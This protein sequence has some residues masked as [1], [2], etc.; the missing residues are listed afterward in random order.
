VKTTGELS[1]LQLDKLYELYELKGDKM[2]IAIHE[3]MDEFT[4]HEIQLA[5]G[6]CIY[7]F[8]DGYADQF[9]GPKG[10]K[11]MYKNFKQ[12]LIDNSQLSMQEQKEILEKQ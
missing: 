4:N 5:Q 11:F 1:T 2:P 7:L 8:T 12:L 9:G 10:K 6:D 3:R